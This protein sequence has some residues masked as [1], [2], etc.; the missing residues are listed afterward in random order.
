VKTVAETSKTSARLDAFFKVAQKP[1]A[2]V[3]ASPSRSRLTTSGL[4]SATS[5]ATNQPGILTRSLLSIYYDSSGRL[6]HFQLSANLLNL[7][8]LIFY[9]CC[10]TRN[11]SFQFRDPLLLFLEII[12]VHLGFGALGIAHSKL[13][14]A[15]RGNVG[16]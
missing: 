8:G 15:G 2:D 4:T 16:A 1:G 3:A 11:R 7:R 9:R 10:E 13:L 14:P 5:S 6:S 12:E